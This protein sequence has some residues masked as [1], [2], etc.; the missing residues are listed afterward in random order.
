MLTDHVTVAD[1]AES[2]KLVSCEQVQ[3]L[4]VMG[5]RVFPLIE[6]ADSG[7][8]MSIFRLEA[9]PGDGVPTHTHL[10]DDEVFYILEGRMRVVLDGVESVVGPGSVAFLP[11]RRPHAWFTDGDQPLTTLII[12]HPAMIEGMFRQIDAGPSD[13]AVPM[14][15]HV[16][17]NAKAIGI[18]FN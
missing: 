17:A 7:G 3:A 2:G 14:M 12:T 5:T 8:R 1:S 18:E 6:G 9:R 4:N 11:R 15:D 16:L 13:P 10:H